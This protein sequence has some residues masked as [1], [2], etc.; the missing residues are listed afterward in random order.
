MA[1]PL[2]G[3]AGI[4]TLVLRTFAAIVAFKVILI[5]LVVV[6]LPTILNNVFHDLLETMMDTATAQVA[7]LA[8]MSFSMQLTGMGAYLADCFRLPECLSL[9]LS[10]LAVAFALRVLRVY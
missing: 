1:L 8:P 9:T 6:F 2:V 7:D 5:T 4:I 10:S 3:I